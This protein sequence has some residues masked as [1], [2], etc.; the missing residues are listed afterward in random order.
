MSKQ[1]RIVLK[2]YFERGDR[3]TQEQFEDLIDSNLI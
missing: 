3:P 1:S 2:S